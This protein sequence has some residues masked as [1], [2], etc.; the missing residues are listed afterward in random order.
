MPGYNK[1]MPASGNSGATAAASGRMSDALAKVRRGEMTLEEY[2]DHQVE[3][4]V[5]HLVGVVTPEQLETVKETLRAQLEADP[6]L[7]EMVGHATGTD[8]VRAKGD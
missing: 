5:K 8:P 1:A 4:A 2:L 3:S 7:L 6:A